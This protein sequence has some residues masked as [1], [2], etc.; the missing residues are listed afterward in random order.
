MTTNKFHSR[1]IDQFHVTN[2][3][4]SP[5]GTIHLL[6]STVVHCLLLFL[7]LTNALTNRHAVRYGARHILTLARVNLKQS[8]DS[9]AHVATTS[10]LDLTLGSVFQKTLHLGAI[11][12]GALGR[13]ACGGV[14]K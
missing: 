8:P 2:L 9:L 5:V 12:R 3:A 1:V 7:E 14:K 4:L 6:S 10:R 11:G 13:G